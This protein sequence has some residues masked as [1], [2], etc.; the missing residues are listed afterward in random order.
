MKKLVYLITFGV[1]AAITASPIVAYATN[2]LRDDGFQTPT[3]NIHCTIFED[4]G[5]LRCDIIKN[6]A[7]LPP[8]P[9]DCDLDWGNAFGMGLTGAAQR[10]CH[11]DT[12]VAG[13]NPVLGYGKT[14]R[15][16]GFTCTSKT[17]GLTCTNRDK[18]G[19]EISQTKQRLF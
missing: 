13:T 19:W 15:K 11:G 1:A 17:T 16:G 9:K 7:K 10:A 6:R 14:W 4:E 3:R 5:L 18:K 12:I 2:G 8:K